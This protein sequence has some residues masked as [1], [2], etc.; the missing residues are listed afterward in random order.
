MKNKIF[1]IAA[2]LLLA[3][4]ESFG[5]LQDKPAA[6]TAKETAPAP[7]KKPSPPPA[8]AEPEVSDARK[9]L[10]AGIEMYKAGN[11]NGAIKQLGAPELANADKPLQLEALKYTAFSYCVT[12]RTTLCRQQFVKAFKLDKSFDLSAG[13][14]GHPLWTPS[15][16]RARKEAA[17]KK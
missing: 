5:P 15:F 10:N 8:P 13:E 6:P 3:G 16:E 7:V 9:A 4:C 14:K 1:L 17:K 11:F 12:N 2:T